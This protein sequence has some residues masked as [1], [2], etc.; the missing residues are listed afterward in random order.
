MTVTLKNKPP[1]A[2]LDTALRRAGFKHGEAV[3]FKVS[4]KKVTIV[5][6]SADDDDTL[7]PEEAKK[8]RLAMKQ[9]R[10]GKTIPWSRVKHELGL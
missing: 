5:P 8:L 1:V 9:V 10:Q 7:T 2:Q 6:I 3:E 4:R